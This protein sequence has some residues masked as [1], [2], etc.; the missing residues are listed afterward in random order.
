M[1]AHGGLADELVFTTWAIIQLKA[2]DYAELHSRTPHIVLFVHPQSHNP[3]TK[4]IFISFNRFYL[5]SSEVLWLC[6][7]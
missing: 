5:V 1:S 2:G 7:V 6:E 3:T 4:Y